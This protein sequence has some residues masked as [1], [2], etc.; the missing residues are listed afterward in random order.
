[1]TLL[2]HEHYL[3]LNFADLYAGKLVAPLSWKHPRDLFDVGLWL[4]DDRA[5][6]IWYQSFNGLEA[7][8][9]IIFKI[10]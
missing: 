3:R 4:Q 9:I 2:G 6:D 7:D 1:M 10:K 8:A 5:N